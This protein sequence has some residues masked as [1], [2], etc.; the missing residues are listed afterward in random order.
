MRKKQF[1]QIMDH[2]ISF[3]NN[4]YIIYWCPTTRHF[5]NFCYLSWN[6]IKH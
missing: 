6:D 5:N 1:K 4:I 3:N 2:Y